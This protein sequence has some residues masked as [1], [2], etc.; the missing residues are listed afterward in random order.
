MA[1]VF[2]FALTIALGL[3]LPGAAVRAVGRRGRGGGLAA[4]A[5]PGVYG[6]GHIA[7]PT[8]PGLLLWAATALAF[9][10]GLHE[11]DA[12]RWRVLVGVLLGLAF[13]E[14]MAAVLV[15]LPLL[16]LAGRRPPAADASR[17][18]GGRADWIDGL[19]DDGGDARPAGPGVPGDPPPAAA[20]CPRRRS[21]RTCSSTARRATCRG[22]SWRCPLAGLARPAA[23]G[24]AL[25]GEPDLGG[26]AAGAGD[27]DG[28]PGVRARWSAGWATR[29]GGARRC[30]GWPT[31]TCSTPT[32]A[33]ALPDIQIIY[34]GQIYEYSLPWHNAWVLIGDHGPGRHPRWPRS[35][36]LV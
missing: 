33:G 19:V 23:A 4:A 22:R 17:R 18:P 28:D 30:R 24:P 11:P 12:R 16:A 27:L 3:R 25:P 10:K 7:A 2:E 1:S 5:C 20:A 36:G 14:K 26:R 34:F 8:R 9:W 13:V 6:D 15:L 31:I 35:V 21:R 29:P 32:A